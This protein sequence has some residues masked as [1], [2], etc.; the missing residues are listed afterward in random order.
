MKRISSSLVAATVAAL[1]TCAPVVARAQTDPAPEG[2]P[3]EGTAPEDTPP[4][5]TPPEGAPPEGS[6]PEGTP[7]PARTGF[8]M[9]L[10]TGYMVPF[11]EATGAAQDTMSNTFSG[12]VPFIV[13]IGG[14]PTPHL[15]V[16]G[17]LGLGF[18]G[19]AGSSSQL[20]SQA[21]ITCVTASFRI[22][23]E[24]Q[25]H[26]TPEASTNPWIGY[27]IGIESTAFSGANGNTNY[28]VAAVGWEFA[29][30]MAGVD[31]RLSK[32]IGIGP[33]VDFSL[34]EYNTLSIKE[35]GGD[36]TSGSIANPALHEWLLVGARMV[37]FP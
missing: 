34:G 3:P 33:M 4:E 19:T 5:G 2:T 13:D 22:G 37:I 23:A 36:T 28:S 21:N 35:N 26:F 17:Y 11:G 29:H 20:C 16:G 12:Q 32:S 1:F 15:F 25:Y 24:V 8:Q 14:K 7:P 30:F 6:A 10:R 18:G 31:F 27:G 9:A